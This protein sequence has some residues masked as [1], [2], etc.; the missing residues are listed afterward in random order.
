[1]TSNITPGVYEH[2]KGKRYFVLGL[3]KNTE[4][5]EVCVVYRPLYETDWPHLVHRS[6]A[7]FQENVKINGNDVPRFKLIAS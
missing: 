1:M 5:N 3:T 6:L 2:Y 7:M 4:T